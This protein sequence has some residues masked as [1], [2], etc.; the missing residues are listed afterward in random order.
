M[1]IY[2]VFNVCQCELPNNVGLP[3]VEKQNNPI[4]ACEKI[5][6]E[7]P[8]PLVIKHK[9]SQAFYNPVLNYINMPMKNSFINSESY[10][11][12]LFHEMTHWA[13][14]S[15]RLNRPGI[16]DIKRT[17]ESYSFEEL[18]AQLGASF[19]SNHAGI[20]SPVIDNSAAYISGWLDMLKN[21]K[22]LILKASAAAQSAADY[23]LNKKVEYKNAIDNVVDFK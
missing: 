14:H 11:D 8:K 12:A 22:P 23:I 20:L 1:R 9:E 13:G 6:T 15:T 4:L 7:C 16:A 19:L 10:Y 17:K 3:F 21:D 18:I 5:I 2:K